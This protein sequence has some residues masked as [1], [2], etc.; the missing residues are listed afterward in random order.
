MYLPLY[1]I[2]ITTIYI[3]YVHNIQKN[4]KTEKFKSSSFPSKIKEKNTIH[5]EMHQDAIDLLPISKQIEINENKNNKSFNFMTF[6]SNLNDDIHFS[7]CLQI[8]NDKREIQNYQNNCGDQAFQYNMQHLYSMS[9]VV[10]DIG[11]HLGGFSKYASHFQLYIFEPIPLFYNK[12]L[13]TFHDS[14][15]VQV[16]NY[17]LS[18]TNSIVNISME[19]VDGMGS[20][21]FSTDS[22]HSIP[23]QMKTLTEAM[24]DLGIGYIH[25]LNI[26]CQAVSLIY[27]NIYAIN[28]CFLK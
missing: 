28:K 2:I 5:S 16:K 24:E 4:L 7:K 19:G 23:V 1:L 15:S 3:L 13:D 12:L 17:G 21:I 25:H 27:W 14:K 6:V 26:N 20:T 10:F 11:G 9:S 8:S 18:K 22:I